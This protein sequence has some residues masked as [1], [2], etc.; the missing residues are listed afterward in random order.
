MQAIAV[1]LSLIL[2][3]WFTSSP[4]A[5]TQGPSQAQRVV[6]DNPEIIQLE[7]APLRRQVSTDV[8][9]KISGPFKPRDRI[10]FNLLGT[11]T[12]LIESEVRR[13][14]TYAQN[15]PRLLRD[16]Q[17]VEYRKDIA[18]IIKA[19]HTRDSDWEPVSVRV[20]KLIPNEPKVLQTPDLADWYDR[21]GP[22]RYVLSNEHRFI[23]GGKWV[24]SMALVFEVHAT[25]SK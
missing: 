21:L 17:E 8:Y 18:E 25:K 4:I 11:N 16:N 19:R 2:S 22:G 13:W 14:D 3:F 7:F 15:K 24:N 10:R 6:L 20:I 1:T 9:E 12:S 23:Q 5:S